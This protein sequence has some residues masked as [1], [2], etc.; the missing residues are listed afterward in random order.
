[1]TEID[2]D[3]SLGFLI[4]D[5]SRLMRHNFNRRAQTLG[6]S[7][8]QARALGFLSREEGIRQVALADKLEI[9][10][11]TLARLLDGLQDLGFITRT[12]DPADRRAFRLHLTSQ[13]RSMI[14][15]MWTLAA[16]TRQEAV[17]DIS[18]EAVA[19]TLETLR[20]M[21]NNLLLAETCGQKP[22]ARTT[23]EDV[24]ND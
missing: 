10:P 24:A 9:H 19:Q 15:R 13:G 18:E 1:M 20:R 17:A 21:K 7:L 4:G 16:E 5:L 11:M 6:L 2:P 8:A 22:A 12:A 3:A 23:R 14:G